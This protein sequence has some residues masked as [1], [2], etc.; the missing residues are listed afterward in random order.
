MGV[1][2]VIMCDR[3]GAIYEG[4]K[5]GM[6]QEKEEIARVTNR[7]M[8]KDSLADAFKE[9]TFYRCSGH[10][11]CYQKMI[12]AMNPGAI[13]MAIANPTPGIMPD[14]EEASATIGAPVVQTFQP[15]E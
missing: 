15:G 10:S 5:E 4:R 12:T 11:A 6:N 14:V 3:H 9:Q 1:K 7:D 8:V 13:V 2:N